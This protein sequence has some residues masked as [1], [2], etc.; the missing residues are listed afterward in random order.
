M[1]PK[2]PHR[3][4][5]RLLRIVLLI[6]VPALALAGWYWLH[7]DDRMTPPYQNWRWFLPSLLYDEFDASA[8]ALRGMNAELGRQ[9]GAAEMPRGVVAPYYAQN[10]EAPRPRKDRY[11][12]EYPHAAL[13]LFRA[14]YWIQPGWRDTPIPPGLPDGS[15]H[16]IAQHD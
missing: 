8:M 4:L 15:Y 7:P 12:L 2:G 11:F 3:T 13:L 6:A 9:A 16:N 5:V 10:I 14:G 1:S